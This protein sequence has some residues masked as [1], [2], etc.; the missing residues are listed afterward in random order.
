MNYTALICPG[1][2]ERASSDCPLDPIRI[3]FIETPILQLPLNV[4]PD[5]TIN[6]LVIISP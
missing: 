2:F 6:L 4:A 5:S 1:S 3:S